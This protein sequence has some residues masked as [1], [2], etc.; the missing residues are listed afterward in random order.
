MDL[1]S[2]TPRAHEIIA[3]LEGRLPEKTLRHT[4]SVAEWSVEV[5][6]RVPAF[7]NAV[8]QCLLAGLLHDFCKAVRPDEL[9]LQA[10]YYGIEVS[11]AQRDK[12]MLLHGPIAAHEARSRFGIDDDAIFEA[13]Y[14]HTTGFPN[15][16]VVGQILYLC[17]FSE[18]LRPYPEAHEARGLLDQHGFAPALRFAA[19]NKLGHVLRKSLPDPLT[20]AFVHWL[21]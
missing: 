8:E 10:A 9:L 1:A 16:G 6:R 2:L 15:M 21:G 14:F 5:C 17:D 12:P 18:P 20:E 13:I 11:N 7:A 19:Q 3:A 4:L